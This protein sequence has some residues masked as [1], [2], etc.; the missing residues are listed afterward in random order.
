MRQNTSTT[1]S[2]SF[3]QYAL[4]Y[5]YPLYKW[6]L[7]DLEDAIKKSVSGLSV[8]DLGCGPGF[9]LETF[10]K[11]HAKTVCGLDISLDMLKAAAASHRAKNCFLTLGD[12]AFLP[13]KNNVFDVVFS[14][15]SVFFWHDKKNALKS[16]FRVLKKGAA[17]LIGGGF[18]LS[19]PQ[20]VV[21]CCN[22]LRNANADKHGSSPKINPDELLSL[23]HGIGGSSTILSAPKRGFWLFWQK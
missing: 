22:A 2:A 20:T 14:R 23:A 17:A 16:V 1:T 3:E 5:H 8:L 4:K 9:M 6:F 21:D 18:G 15:G 11:A 19:T 7:R 10:E 12:S 13:F